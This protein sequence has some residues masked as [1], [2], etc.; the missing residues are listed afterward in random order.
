MSSIFPTIFNPCNRYQINDQLDDK[1]KQ[2]GKLGVDTIASVNDTIKDDKADD[3]RQVLSEV[4]A[5]LE[6]EFGGNWNV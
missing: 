6:R 3:E 1:V 2:L 5:N 4:K